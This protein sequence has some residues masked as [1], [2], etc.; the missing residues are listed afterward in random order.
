MIVK[1]QM[2]EN[3]VFV[4]ESTSLRMPLSYR[5][6]VK[7]ATQLQGAAGDVSTKTKNLPLNG[8]GEKSAG[9]FSNMAGRLTPFR[10][11]NATRESSVVF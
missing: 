11:A 4:S 1:L 5:Q 10:R 2:S 7:M 3:D 9:F 8:S 6:R